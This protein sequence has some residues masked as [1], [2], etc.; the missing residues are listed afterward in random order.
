LTD[1]KVDGCESI[2]FLDENTLVAAGHVGNTVSV[3]VWK[4][5]PRPSR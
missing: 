1:W 4:A 3:G 2:E 5:E